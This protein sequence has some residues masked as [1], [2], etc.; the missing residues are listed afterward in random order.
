MIAPHICSRNVSLDDRT[1]TVT[2][3]CSMIFVIAKSSFRSVECLMTL[4][5]KS[6]AS[7][8]LSSPNRFPLLASPRNL[9][10]H[11]RY[12]MF[13]IIPQH[14]SVLWLEII[15]IPISVQL[16]RQPGRPL[17]HAYTLLCLLQS[18][19]LRRTRDH[20]TQVIKCPADSRSYALDEI[21]RKTRGLFLLFPEN[22]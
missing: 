17:I 11:L 5:P 10:R 15:S 4:L 3:I 14:Q 6:L 2:L 9:G 18:Q 16:R 1:V 7:L 22:S 13:L 19:L 21:L 12:S 8:A 20:I